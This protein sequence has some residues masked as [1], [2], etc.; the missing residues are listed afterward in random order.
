M[1]FRIM[2]L[3][4]KSRFHAVPGDTKTEDQ[5]A[6]AMCGVKPSPYGGA[7]WCTAHKPPYKI[8][9]PKCRR[10]AVDALQEAFDTLHGEQ[11]RERKD[12]E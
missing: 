11:A 8:T 9:C 5:D 7:F 4:G 12:G 10:W 1:T 6:K 2:H 3:C